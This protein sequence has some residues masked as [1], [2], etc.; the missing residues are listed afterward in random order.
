MNN[1]MRFGEILS[2]IRKL[3]ADTIIKFDFGSQVPKGFHSYR[4]YYQ[5]VAFGFTDWRSDNLTSGNFANIL[6]G[7]LGKPMEGYKGGTY[8]VKESS[9]VW[10]SPTYQEVS[11]TIITGI[12]DLGYG[13]AVIETAYED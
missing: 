3:P 9:Y 1:G 11:G 6:Q 10:V 8:Y 5:D 13:Y 4:G 7:W 12:K 2:E